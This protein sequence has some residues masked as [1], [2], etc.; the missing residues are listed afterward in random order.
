MAVTHR[1]SM[2][3]LL[4]EAFDLWKQKNAMKTA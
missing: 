2:K 1:L 4:I 3:E